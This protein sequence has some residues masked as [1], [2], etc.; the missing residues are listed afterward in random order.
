MSLDD[1]VWRDS[2]RELGAAG[3][4]GV[5][6][7]NL[8]GPVVGYGINALTTVPELWSQDHEWRA[9]EKFAPKFVR[10]VMRTLR[11]GTEGALNY[12]GD[13]VVGS[14]LLGLPYSDDLNMW[15]LLWQASGFGAEKLARRYQKTNDLKNY[16]N[17]LK[18]RRTR[19][20]TQ[21]YQAY[22]ERDQEGM[23][24]AIEA[25]RAWNKANPLAPPIDGKTLSRSLKTRLRYRGE[26]VN[27]ASVQKGFRYLLKDLRM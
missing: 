16:E 23:Q 9:A 26:S 22:I 4:K 18:Q 15:N 10:D 7:E 20:L 21:Y 12:R 6:Y 25:A 13:E 8:A 14:D 3:E 5:I 11:Y 24:A 19:I 2:D 27:G 17:Y 1:L